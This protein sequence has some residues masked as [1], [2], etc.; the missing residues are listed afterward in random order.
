MKVFAV[1]D[2]NVL[3][4]ALISKRSDTAVVLAVESLFKGDVTPL[5]NDEIIAEYEEVLHREKFNLPDNLTESIISYIKSNGIS[6]ERVPSAEE[7]PDPDDIVFYEVALSKEDTFL[8]TGN[9]KHFPQSPIVVTPAEFL[10]KIGKL[11]PR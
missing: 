7:F 8:I 9:T 1:Y 2:T 3:V 6:S 4:S 10:Q 11:P 5:Y